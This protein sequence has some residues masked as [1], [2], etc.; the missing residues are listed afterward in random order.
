MI[1]PLTR[2]HTTKRRRKP[3]RPGTTRLQCSTNK[4]IRDTNKG[5]SMTSSAEPPPPCPC[6][7]ANRRVYGY[8]WV[9]HEI[10]KSCKAHRLLYHSTLGLRDLYRTC[11]ESNKEEKKKQGAR[12]R[13]L[14]GGLEASALASA[15]VTTCVSGAGLGLGVQGLGFRV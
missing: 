6:V 13:T 12:R 7:I 8:L 5:L 15:S 9:N 1:Q 2:P 3:G 4:G 11:I 10:T 14:R